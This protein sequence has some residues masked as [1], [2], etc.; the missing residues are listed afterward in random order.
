[1]RPCPCRSGSTL[2]RHSSRSKQPSTLDPTLVSVVVTD[3]IIWLGVRPD[4]TESPGNGHLAVARHRAAEAI[5]SWLESTTPSFRPGVY[6]LRAT[7]WDQAS[8]QN[9]TDRRSGGEPMVVT[10]PFGCRPCFV[11]AF[12]AE[13]T[14]RRT[15]KRGGKRRTV[16]RRVIDLRPS[17]DVRYGERVAIQGRLENR[18]GQPVPN[19]PVQVFSGT[20]T[21]RGQLIGVVSTDA[22]GQFTYGACG[23]LQHGRCG[24]ST[25]EPRCMLPSESAVNLLTSAASTLRATP[26][27][28]KNGQSVRFSGTL[29]A[30]PTP[31]AG[32]LI[33]LQVVL[34]GRWQTFRTTRT[35]ADGSWAI[36]YQFRRTC[37]LLRYRFRA[38]LPAEAGYAFQTGYTRTRRITVRGPRCE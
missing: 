8:N 21:E 11:P 25:R 35:Q 24:S 28:L 22:A 2:S 1:M 9:S 23:R 6:L 32:K 33:E 19:A 34:S 4:R 15:V 29:R 26:R 3:R 14:V 5:V 10:L 17:A 27:R 30:L 37:G 7:A 36:R 18:D 13:R 38:R 31:P 12:G 20:P 16:R